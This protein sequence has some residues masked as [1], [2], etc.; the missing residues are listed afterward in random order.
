MHNQ[1]NVL[2]T[3]LENV[4]EL[5]NIHKSYKDAQSTLNILNNVNLSLTKGQ[6]IA[7]VSPSG[8]GKS[9]L[10]QIAGLVSS[11]NSGSVFINNKEC[12]FKDDTFLTKSR[13]QNIGF[14]YQF[15][16]LLKEFT[17][18]EN[19][20]LPL[21]TVNP[22][23]KLVKEKALHLLEKVN[24]AD[25]ANNFPHELSGGQSQRVAIARAFINSPSLLIA[26]EPTGNLDNK[27]ASQVFELM[28]DF[29]AENNTSAIVATHNT[30]LAKLLTKQYKINEEGG[31]SLL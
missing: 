3:A 28:L 25:K 20:M 30:S 12:D 11:P 14:I 6:A 5:K 15:H 31:L 19:V 16:H 13:R 24:L 26:D 9:T 29:I 27:L 17:S 4:L 2:N 1:Q 10:L 8:S 23:V 7:L 21:L 22:N 18:V